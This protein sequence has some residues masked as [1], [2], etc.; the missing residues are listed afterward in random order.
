MNT[1]LAAGF[2]TKEEIDTISK[3]A[4][5]INELMVEF[6]KE[7]N[8]D[9]IDFKIEFGRFHGQIL[10]VDEISPDTRRF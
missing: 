6:F 7:C 8:V 2:A 9:L 1:I 10:L 3:M 4:L 5:R